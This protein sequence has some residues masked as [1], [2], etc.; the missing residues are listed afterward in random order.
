[1]AQVL[2]QAYQRRRPAPGLLRHSDRDGLYSSLVYQHLL[3]ECDMT[4]SMSRT[5]NCWDKACV[6]SFFASLKNELVAFE[7]FTTQDEAE[8]TVFEWIEVFYNRVRRHSTLGYHSP[9]DF[10]R[11]THQLKPSV[12]EN[13]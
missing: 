6:E 9:V 2:E 1:V 5:G 4:P 10:E 12:H 13:G 8:T 11:L 3:K 7:R